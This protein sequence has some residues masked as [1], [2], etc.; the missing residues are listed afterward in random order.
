MVL[1]ALD[2]HQWSGPGLSKSQVEDIKWVCK[3]AETLED[4]R[5]DLIYAPFVIWRSQ[6]VPVAVYYDM[7]HPRASKLKY[8]DLL[9]EFKWFCDTAITLRDF[10]LLAD[11][12][13]WRPE[14]WPQRPRLPTREGA[15]S[16]RRRSANLQ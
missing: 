2:A 11:E 10:C 8:K 13:F 12:Q 6:P 15:K 7:G 9:V 14:S 16:S 3:Q 5:N 1:A 4:L